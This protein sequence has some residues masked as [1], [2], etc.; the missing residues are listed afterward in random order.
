MPLKNKN[1]RGCILCQN[2]KISAITDPI[3]FNAEMS[4]KDLRDKLQMQNGF[5]VELTEIKAHTRHLFMET[6]EEKVSRKKERAEIKTI[7]TIDIINDELAEINVDIRIAREEGRDN[8]MEFSKLLKTKLDL[9][10][11]KAKI[12]GE[13]T[14]GTIVVP[15]WLERLEDNEK[16]RNKA[17]GPGN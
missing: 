14:D 4:H 2:K 8:T 15:A 10:N 7:N 1:I 6:D 9:M 16:S 13:I 5:M 17:I 11:L 12:E 3:L